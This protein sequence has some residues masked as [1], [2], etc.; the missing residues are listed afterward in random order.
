MI[1]NNTLVSEGEGMDKNLNQFEEIT[2]DE[3][4][5]ERKTGIIFAAFFMVLLLSIMTG[6]YFYY[7]GINDERFLNSQQAELDDME[8]SI[9]DNMQI[10][11][12][13]LLIFSRSEVAKQ[14]LVRDDKISRDVFNDIFLSLAKEISIFQQVRLIDKLGMEIVRVDNNKGVFEVVPPDALQD[15]SDRYYFTDT[16]DTPVDSIYT[17]PFD[18]NVERGQIEVPFKPMIRLGK[19]YVDSDGRT[20]GM[21]ILNVLGQ[22]LINDIKNKNIHEGD[23][24]YLLN[25]DGYYIYSDDYDKNFAFMFPEKKEIGFFSDYEN[26]WNRIISGERI[27]ETDNGNFYIRET[28]L[29]NQQH[30]KTSGNPFYLIMFAPASEVNREDRNLINLMAISVI[31]F[32]PLVLILGWYLGNTRTRNKLYREKLK[33]NAARDSLTGLYN[34]R[35]IIT[36]LTQMMG[37]S[38]RNKDDLSIVFIDVNNLKYVNDNFGHKMGDKMI[39][40]AADSITSSVRTTDIVARLGGDEFLVVL[41]NCDEENAHEIMKRAL[42][43]FSEKGIEEMNT[44]WIISYGCAKYNKSETINELISRA[45]KLMYENKLLTKSKRQ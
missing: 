32:L 21:M 40:G 37:L 34:H 3:K 6:I 35:M 38:I 2:S 18:L 10:A 13:P 4:H 24:V 43:L 11:I 36:L 27:I 25:K 33:E 23:K 44:Q 30:Y 26:I 28:T 42:Q 17:S 16:L 9:H 8:N 31:I 29:L 22:K 1:F 45:D 41:P 20:S 14:M 19:A 5:A 15:K 7:H 12:S 39:I